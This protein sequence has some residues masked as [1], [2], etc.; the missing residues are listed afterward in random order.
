MKAKNPIESDYLLIEPDENILRQVYAWSQEDPEMEHFTC[1]PLKPL[2][3]FST[4]KAKQLELSANN[5]VIAKVLV[6]KESEKVALGRCRCFDMNPRNRSTEIGYYLPAGHRQRGLGRIM[7]KKMLEL[8][9]SD[10]SLQMNKIYASTA[11][12][13]LASVKLLKQLGFTKDG[14]NREH[15]WIGNKKYNQLIY[16]IL[17]R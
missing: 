1:R 10:D 15:Y 11:S 3:D 12:C 4:W 14:E 7:L 13:N 16:S 5:S 6:H 9:F 8:V 2:P 17:K